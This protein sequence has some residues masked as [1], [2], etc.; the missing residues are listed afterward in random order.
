[1]TTFRRPGSASDPN[2]TQFI[3]PRD[4]G[5]TEAPPSNAGPAD[6]PAAGPSG[7]P[8]ATSLAAQAVRATQAGQADA[9]PAP[10]APTTPPDESVVRGRA[11]A[12]WEIAGRP[13]GQ[14][15]NHWLRAEKEISQ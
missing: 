7:V 10:A 2:V 4:G 6:K 14:A 12:I 8:P 15:V 5:L 3:P 13:D 9:P 1:M 11:Y